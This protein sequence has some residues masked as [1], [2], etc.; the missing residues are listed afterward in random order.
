MASVR[1][2]GTIV[3]WLRDASTGTDTV[4]TCTHPTSCLTTSPDA[5]LEARFEGGAERDYTVPGHPV[6]R[7]SPL[8]SGS[9]TGT[10]TTRL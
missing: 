1:S 6:R 9:I 10:C 3:I 4:P 7:E 2:E 8:E 5:S